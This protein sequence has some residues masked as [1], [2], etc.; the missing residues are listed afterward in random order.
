MLPAQLTAEHFKNYPPKAQAVA[1]ENVALLQDLPLG[2]V[3]FLL[4]EIIGYDWKFPVEQR[5]LDAQLSYL[6]ALWP[7]K[8]KREM[9]RFAQLQLDPK[10]GSFDWVNSPAQFLEQLSAQLWATQQ[11]DE[12]RSASEAY[13][14]KF[15]ETLPQT[16]LPVPRLGIVVLGQGTTENQYVL[17]RKLRRRGVYFS[18]V[19]PANGLEAILETVKARA[20]NHPAPY[21]HWYIE[22]GAKESSSLTGLSCVCY[23]ELARVRDTLAAKMKAAYEAPT[24]SPEVLRTTLAQIVPETVGMAGEGRDAVMDRFQLSLFTEGSGTQIYSTSFVQWAAREALRRAQPLT[25]LVRYAPRQR[26]R[27]MEELLAG[28]QSKAVTD[29]LGSLIDADMGAYYTW[30][31]QQRLTSADRSGFLVWFEGRTEALAIG[32][33]LKPGT[34]DTTAVDVSG[35]LRKVS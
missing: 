27:S 33:G 22:G 25:L 4:R 6:K 29:P 20:A 15:N 5:E 35:L 3:P 7:G 26:E 1:V 11:L 32:P 31:N 13:V 17:F 2:F 21:G 16:A 9:E 28:T 30:L 34:E 8:R 18:R 12:F 23:N 24:F 10:L 14:H 19:N